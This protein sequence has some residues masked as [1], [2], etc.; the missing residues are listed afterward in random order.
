M[1]E[2]P[3]IVEEAATILAQLGGRGFLLMTGAR[4]LLAA[5]RSPHNPRPWLRMDLPP[6][7]SGANRFRVL[8]LPSDTYQVDFYHQQLT[9]GVAEISQEQVFTDVYADEL[10][11]LFRRVTGFETRLPVIIRAAG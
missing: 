4:N 7:Q 8:L 9:A 11:G 6:N 1:S 2:K 3:V 5:G 10:P